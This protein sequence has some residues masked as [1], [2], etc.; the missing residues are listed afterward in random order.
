MSK[1]GSHCS[2]GHLKHKLWPKEGWESNS[3]ESTSFDSR[4][5]KVENRPEI[6]D[7]REC[8]TYRWK[9]L[10]EI[11]NFAS[12]GKSIGGLLRKLWSFKVA[13]VP[14]LRDF[15]TLTRESRESR[16]KMA[17]WMPP[18]QRVTEY[19]IRGK[20]LTSLR[21]EDVGFLTKGVRWWLTPEPGVC[22]CPK[23]VRVH[24]WLVPT[25]KRFHDEF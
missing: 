11:Y 13:G 17:I 2:F 3:R 24:P 8:A 18:P 12:D 7:C 9:G 4:P 20:W 25:P 22:V 19:T 16:D 14:N 1:M 5:L 15:G 10:D 23:W 21:G 6:L